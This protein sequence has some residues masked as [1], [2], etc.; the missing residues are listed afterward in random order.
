MQREDM[1]LSLL[2]YAA[3]GSMGRGVALPS[4]TFSPDFTARHPFCRGAP[5][6]PGAQLFTA[7]ESGRAEQHSALPQKRSV[8]VYSVRVA[9]GAWP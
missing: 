8:R 6:A 2:I 9:G 4:H 3:A 7:I 1:F 5:S